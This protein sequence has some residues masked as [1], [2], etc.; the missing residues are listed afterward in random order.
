MSF[1]VLDLVS[2]PFYPFIMYVILCSC[3]SNSAPSSPVKNVHHSMILIQYPAPSTRLQCMLFYVSAILFPPLGPQY[4]V[5][6]YMFLIQYLV[7]ST[8]SQCVLVYVPAI[9]MPPLWTPVQCSHENTH[10]SSDQCRRNTESRA[11]CV[12]GYI[13]HY[14]ISENKRWWSGP[15][16]NGVPAIGSGTQGRHQRMSKWASCGPLSLETS[17]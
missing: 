5:F 6:H 2:G 1:Y 17:L 7:P 8:L 4:N 12:T 13:L 3:N 16:N 14:A 10:H 15:T 9:V 11:Q